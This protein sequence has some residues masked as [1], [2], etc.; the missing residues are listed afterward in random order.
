MENI[1]RDTPDGTK[2]SPYGT[3]TDFEIEEFAGSGRLI[4]E[5]F[6]KSRIKQACYEL[7]AGNI[8]YDLAD[9]DLRISVGKSEFIL[10]KP[11]QTVVIIS[12]ERFE[13]PDDMLARILTKGKLF[14]IG[15][16]PVNTYADPGFKGRLGI[17]FFNSSTKYLKIFPGEPIA[18]VEFSRLWSAVERPYSGQHGYE[19]SI[20]PIPREMILTDKEIKQ[21]NLIRDADQEMRR[22]YGSEIANVVTRISRYERWLILASVLYFIMNL[23]LIALLVKKDLWISLSTGVAVG[24]VAN[25][26]TAYVTWRVTDL[27]RR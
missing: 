1:M 8:Y 2:V 13:I 10:I 7:R 17:V 22:S 12:M 4:T 6:D 14:S 18:K 15:L 20:W 19:T 11:R 24:I 23:L 5:A 21:N 27:I 26:M 25:V 9:T 16:L 3:L